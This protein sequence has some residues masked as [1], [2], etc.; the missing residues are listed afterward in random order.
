MPNTPRRP[1]PAVL[2]NFMLFDAEAWARRRRGGRDAFIHRMTS[3]G[4][5]ALALVLLSLVLRARHTGVPITSLFDA[6][7]TTIVALCAILPIVLR[8]LAPLEWRLLETR[9]AQEL[10]KLQSSFGSGP[11]PVTQ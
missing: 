3:F 8:V 5:L 9:Y 4:W 6:Q 7:T 10:A 11:R 1:L 2:L